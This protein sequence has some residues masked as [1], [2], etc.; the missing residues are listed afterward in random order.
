M[1]GLRVSLRLRPNSTAQFVRRLAEQVI[2]MLRKQKGFRDEI[3]FVASAGPEAFGVSLWDDKES[4]NAYDRGPYAEVTKILASLLYGTPKVDAYEVSSST[5]HTL[6]GRYLNGPGSLVRPE[7]SVN[8][9]ETTG[10]VRSSMRLGAD[11]QGRGTMFDAVWTA[12]LEA[13][14][15]RREVR[16]FLARALEDL[17]GGQTQQ[18]TP[19]ELSSLATGSDREVIES[20]RRLDKFCGGCSARDAKYA[21]VVVSLNLRDLFAKGLSRMKEL[22]PDPRETLHPKPPSSLVHPLPPRRRSL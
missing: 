2:P 14:T 3:T 19:V 15:T 18:D 20:Y 1:Y 13:L 21:G 5:F 9:S 7:G 10:H 11:G 16:G 12:S 17:T 6:N 22:P 4:A 8:S